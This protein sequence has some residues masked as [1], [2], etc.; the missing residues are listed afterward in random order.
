MIR[1]QLADGAHA[2]A[3]QMIDVIERAFATAQIDQVFDR[4]DEIL[5]RQN[6]LVE[7][8]V[9]PELLVDLVTANPSEIVFLRI[10]KEPF[11]K[12]ARIGHGWRIARTQTP[13][14]ILERF[15]LIVRR[16]FPERFY[17][18]VVVRN[19]DHL[20]FLDLRAP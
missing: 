6:P 18:R 16:I 1:Q 10:K 19:V 15:L 7:I 17:D 8:D 20:H 13:V 4:G 12:S 3:A 11:Q 2:P 14:N 5:V 9:D